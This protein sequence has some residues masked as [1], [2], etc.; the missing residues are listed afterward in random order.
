MIQ[1]FKVDKM[2]R[3]VTSINMRHVTLFDL[4]P[5]ELPKLME[6]NHPFVGLIRLIHPGGRYMVF[7][8]GSERG[9]YG[10]VDA[11][12]VILSWS[13]E[14]L[15]EG[16]FYAFATAWDRLHWMMEGEV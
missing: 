13:V 3:T 7:S 10:A 15:S 16:T 12:G 1:L 2:D 4:L 11:E 8:L 14:Q 9:N 5:I 6:S